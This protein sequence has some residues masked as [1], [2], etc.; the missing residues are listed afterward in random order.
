MAAVPSQPT[1]SI[2]SNLTKIEKVLNETDL[3]ENSLSDSEL[4]TEDYIY[5][6]EEENNK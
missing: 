2:D 1:Q 5:S 4:E 6:S 3:S